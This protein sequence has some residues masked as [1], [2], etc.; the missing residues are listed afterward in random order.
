[1]KLIHNW[2]KRINNKRTD[3]GE[4]LT[5]IKEANEINNNQVSER[6]LFY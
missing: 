2:K 1:M 3:K 5:Y 4:K 6:S